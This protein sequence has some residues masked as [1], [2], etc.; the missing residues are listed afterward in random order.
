MSPK[1]QRKL[2]SSVKPQIPENIQQQ[3][4]KGRGQQGP[5]SRHLAQRLGATEGGS[6]F[7]LTSNYL[8]ECPEPRDRGIFQGSDPRCLW[9]PDKVQVWDAA[10][11]N[12]LPV[13]CPTHLCC[14]QPGL[15]QLVM[16]SDLGTQE[17]P[18]CWKASW[19][20]DLLPVE[21]PR[22][23]WSLQVKGNLRSPHR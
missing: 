9:V 6:L 5:S 18:G 17:G 10:W 16:S 19:G 2:K 1:K 21:G 15:D 7:P 14:S 4:R 12:A 8:S 13:V 20:P 23:S 3:S 11:A 22:G